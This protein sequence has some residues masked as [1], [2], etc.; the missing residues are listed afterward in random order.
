MPQKSPLYYTISYFFKPQLKFFDNEYILFDEVSGDTYRL[1][2]IE[3]RIIEQLTVSPA[4][5]D[6]LI[7]ACQFDKASASEEMQKCLHQALNK[8]KHLSMIEINQG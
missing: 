7:V 3:G 2:E 8:M 4:S 1:S 6:E 5:F